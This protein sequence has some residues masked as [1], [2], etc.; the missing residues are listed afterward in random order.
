[1][2]WLGLS[3]GLSAGATIG[4]VVMAVMCAGKDSDFWPPRADE[5][6]PK[7]NNHR[8]W[9]EDEVIAWQQRH[10]KK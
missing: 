4:V 8:V 6:L 7:N 1:M 2:F 5:D 3:V 10:C 9:H